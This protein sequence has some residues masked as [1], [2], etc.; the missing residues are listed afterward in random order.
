MWIR[1]GK[2]YQCHIWAIISSVMDTF[3]TV[4]V[5]QSN[6]MI[7]YYLQNVKAI[8]FWKYIVHDVYEEIST[9]SCVVSQCY[10][11]YRSKKKEVVHITERFK[12]HW[13]AVFLGLL[14]FCCHQGSNLSLLQPQVTLF[15]FPCFSSSHFKAFQLLPSSP[16]SPIL[17]RQHSDRKQEEQQCQ[18]DQSCP[19]C[20]DLAC[21][22]S[23]TWWWNVMMMATKAMMALM[24]RGTTTNDGLVTG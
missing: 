21:C 18:T 7:H 9:K 4:F 11:R 16:P 20:Q 2:A 10:H 23:S 14:I 1:H 8:W 22:C 13:V 17:P 6:D 15:P 3:L 5:L 12:T 19:L 24:T